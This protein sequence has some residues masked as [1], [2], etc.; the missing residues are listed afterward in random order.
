MFNALWH[1]VFFDPIYNSLVF[2]ID[3]VPGGDVG[4]AIILTVIMVKLVLL[5]LSLKAVRTQ[6]IMREI[7]PKLKELKE[8]LKDNKEEQARKMLQLFQEYKLNPFMS[9]VLVFIQIPIVFALYFSV[10]KGGGVSLPA[11]NT[12][13]LYSFIPTP[14]VVNMILLGV[15]DITTRN[16][17]LAVLAGVTQYIHTNMSL[18]K[19]TPRD[20]KAEPDFKEDFTRSMQIQMRY[21][22][23]VIIGVAAYSISAAIA[24]YFTISNL[25]AILQEYVVRRKGLK[26]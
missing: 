19:L 14:A 23:P 8:T 20:P 9:I 10:Y 7:E 1:N 24:L 2:F 26:T 15:L 22:L 3:I 4:I 11:I 12:E 16:L 18:P 13:L 17:P 25:M 6:L 5:P 21:V